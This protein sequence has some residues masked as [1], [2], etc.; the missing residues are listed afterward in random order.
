MFF[1]FSK[2]ISLLSIFSSS[3]SYGEVRSITSTVT[4]VLCLGLI[5]WINC[6]QALYSGVFSENP[7]S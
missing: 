1:A 4:F 2:N 5:A 7:N 6:M 3:A